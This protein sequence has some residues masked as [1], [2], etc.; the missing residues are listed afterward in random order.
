MH[1]SIY[2]II[3]RVFVNLKDKMDELALISRTKADYVSRELK[4]PL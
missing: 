1:S 2:K 4:Q 3:V